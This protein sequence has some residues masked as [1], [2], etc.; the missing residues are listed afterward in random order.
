MLAAGEGQPERVL[1]TA[2]LLAHLRRA[3]ALLPELVGD[4]EIRV[5]LSSRAEADALSRAVSDWAPGAVDGWTVAITGSAW[6][7]S[8]RATLHRVRGRFAAEWVA[9]SVAVAAGFE[10][11]PTVGIDERDAPYAG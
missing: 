11:G 5:V 1:G 3:T 10:A 9:W 8:G 7:A 6:P 2:H 4:T